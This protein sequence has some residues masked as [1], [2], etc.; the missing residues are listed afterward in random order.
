MKS[1][2]SKGII[3]IK[4]KLNIEYR[5]CKIEYTLYENEEFE[6]VF[7]P[8]YEVIEYLDKNK[9]FQGIPGIDLDLKEEKYIRK[10]II[11]TFISER[12]PSE[13]RE[14]YYDLLKE[15]NMEYMNPIEYLIK[16]KK[17]YSGD[18][19]YVIPFEERKNVVIYSID[20]DKRFNR[21]SLDKYILD[22]LAAGNKLTLYDGKNLNNIIFFK[23]IELF[24]TDEV[25]EFKRCQMRGINKAKKE[26]KYKGRKP[27]VV[28]EVSFMNMLERV[29]NKEL[30]ARKAAEK[31][32]ISIDKYYRLKKQ[33][34][35]D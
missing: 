14:D 5:V 17:R 24:Y 1:L 3:C 22:N 6:Y 21:M 2:T 19:L 20:K 26:G 34:N 4:D 12:V 30:T 23:M 27:I 13:N 15:V 9:I 16:T 29:S 10:N 18:K 8:N 28:D 32:G 31:L 35:K 7:T 11:P 33:M 25:K